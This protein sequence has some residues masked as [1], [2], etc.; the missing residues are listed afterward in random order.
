MKEI[1]KFFDLLEAGQNSA[2]EERNEYSSKLGYT[3]FE[4]E[5]NLRKWHDSLFK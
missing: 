4:E 5:E 1:E 3:S 2:S